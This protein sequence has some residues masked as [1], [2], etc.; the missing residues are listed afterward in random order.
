LILI[1]KWLLAT[2]WAIFSKIH[3]VTLLRMKWSIQFKQTY[4]SI[5]VAF[6]EMATTTRPTPFTV[7]HFLTGFPYLGVLFR[8]H[9]NSPA[10]EAIVSKVT[11]KN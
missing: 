8:R 3:L 1:K 9:S 11:T 6:N 5:V 4:L 7:R 10:K 2:F